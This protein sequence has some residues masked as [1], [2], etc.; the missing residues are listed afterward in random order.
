M[1]DKMTIMDLRLIIHKFS[2]K[3]NWEKFH[4]PRNLAESIVIEASE[5]LAEFKWDNK[6][7]NPFNKCHVLNELADVMILCLSMA[8]NMNAD[9]TEEILNKIKINSHKYPCEFDEEFDQ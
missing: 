7:N 1:D 6:F 4:T 3:R 5:L 9:L 8:N 2:R